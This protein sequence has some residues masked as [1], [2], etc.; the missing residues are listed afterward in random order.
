MTD[1]SSEL[2]LN[3]KKLLGISYWKIGKYKEALEY[4]EKALKIAIEFY[5]KDHPCVIAAYDNIGCSYESL[6]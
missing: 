2:E 5:S 4:E 6:G 1:K 3:R